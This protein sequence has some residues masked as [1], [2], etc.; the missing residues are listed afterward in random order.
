MC[1]KSQKILLAYLN[2][3]KIIVSILNFTLFV[4]MSNY[5]IPTEWFWKGHLTQKGLYKFNNFQLHHLID[6]QRSADKPVKPKQQHSLS[7]SYSVFLSQSAYSLD[8]WHYILDHP[9]IQLLRN[10][11]KSCNIN[12][13]NKEH[14]EFCTACA[15]GKS[16]R[17]PSPSS[18]NIYRK[19]LDLLYCDLWG[20]ASI[21]STNENRYYLSIVDAFSQHTWLFPLKRKSDTLGVF[22]QYKTLIEKSIG[23]HKAIQT[24]GGG[25]FRVFRSFL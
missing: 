14:L 6:Q 24:D 21:L 11:L 19:P 17:L 4:V 7:T 13:S 3:P 5:R 20:L 2:L 8:M 16:Q 9:N 10:T 23:N 15:Y 25:E 12:F 18:P 22:I 1:Q